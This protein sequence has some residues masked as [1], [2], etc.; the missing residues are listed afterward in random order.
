MSSPWTPAPQTPCL[1]LGW[2]PGAEGT[3]GRGHRL[4]W[5]RGCSSH[6]IHVLSTA[7]TLLPG[8]T[9]G[10]SLAC[11]TWSLYHQ[12]LHRKSR[13]LL[14]AKEVTENAGKQRSIEIHTNVTVYYTVRQS[15]S[16]PHF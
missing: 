10:D 5:P 12:A 13:P 4:A 14:Q 16:D 15:G 11:R 6:V 2:G 7:A 1:G 8:G 9:E 3:W